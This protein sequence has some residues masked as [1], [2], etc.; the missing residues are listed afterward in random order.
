MRLIV[1]DGCWCYSRVAGEPTG[2]SI[3]IADAS[4]KCRTLKVFDKGS[5]TQFGTVLAQSPYPL[6]KLCAALIN[7][8][9][10]AHLT[11][12]DSGWVVSCI[13][14]GPI[15]LILK[16][17]ERSVIKPTILDLAKLVVLWKLALE[18]D[19]KVTAILGNVFA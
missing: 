8:R 9:N 5:L 7:F 4:A 13:R 2:V 6:H 16:N 3:G 18:F 19:G 1:S 10:R 11:G 12:W 17:T 15:E 14:H